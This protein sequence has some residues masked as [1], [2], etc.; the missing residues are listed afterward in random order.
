MRETNSIDKRG[1]KVRGPSGADF[2]WSEMIPDVV[3]EGTEE[4][5]RESSRTVD[6]KDVERDLVLDGLLTN[7]KK[8]EVHLSRRRHQGSE[9]S[10]LVRDVED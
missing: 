10:V 2:M 4:T 8:E 9:H 5:K 3:V 7:R 1:D 6:L